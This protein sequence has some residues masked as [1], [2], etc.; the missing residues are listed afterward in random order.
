[1]CSYVDVV[2]EIGRISS[3]RRR[4]FIGSS[5]SSR[6]SS[7]FQSLDIVAAVAAVAKVAAV[8]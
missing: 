8:L 6:V 4:R 1:M 5:G 7:Y 2:V 3:S